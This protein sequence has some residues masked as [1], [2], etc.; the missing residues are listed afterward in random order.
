MEEIPLGRLRLE[1]EHRA[2][3]GP[4]LRVR[5]AGGRERLRFDCFEPGA[6]F[7]V[8]PE[9]GDAVT[10]IPV[11]GDSIDWVLDE[12]GRDFAGWLARA[13][14]TGDAP[15][16]AALH[17]ALGRA[18]RAMR[19]P[20]LDLDALDLER[21]RARTGEKWRVY[22]DDVLPLWVADMDFP[23]A[24]PIRRRLHRAV[25]LSDLGY[26]MHPRPTG[27]PE[28]F[29]ERAARRLAWRVDPQRVELLTD[30][31]QGMYVALEAWSERGQGAVVQTPIYPPFLGAV[32]NTGRRLVENRLALGPGGY[33]ID[34]D[35][36]RAALTPDTRLLLLCNP[37]NPTGRVFQ[38][39]ELERL[40]ELVL[41]H[42]LVVVADELHG[43]LTYPGHGF[44]PF[45]TLGPELEA[46][47]FTLSAASK[48]FN[49]AG[50]RCA[51]GVFG[52]E[53]LRK[54]FLEVPR[55]LRGGLGGLG[56]EATRAAWLHGDPWLE[57]VLAHLAAN[58]ERVAR[59]VAERLPGVV[60]HTPRATYFA[61]LDCRA[62]GLE[63][64]PFEFFLERAKVGLS[65]GRTFGAAGE[66][67]VRLNFATSRP[68]LDEALER[69]ARALES[70]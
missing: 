69:M 36:L 19:H 13:G 50:M 57:E 15:D 25:E 3:A 11:R 40:A 45:A 60:H 14:V 24:E 70:R 12:L 38:R 5:D 56:I 26:P 21:L 43:E 51:V 23:V 35:A 31:V 28:L 6:H 52:S 4:T 64:S 68:I 63:P 44:V 49:I 17:L 54:R 61:W 27:L 42:D 58:R 1:V 9:G 16:R 8:D 18:E 32:R 37:H 39:G 29:A 67:F 47:T 10:P 41:A 66:G 33:E 7:H 20:P 53:A 55:H 30:V 62:L 34:F 22:P 59:F 65:D 46:R 2:P 48:A